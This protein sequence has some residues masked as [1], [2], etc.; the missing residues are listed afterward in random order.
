MSGHGA[1]EDNLQL[2]NFVIHLVRSGKFYCCVISIDARPNLSFASPVTLESLK[3]D[4]LQVMLSYHNRAFSDY[5]HFDI[6]DLFGVQTDH[7][8]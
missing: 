6:G 4:D 2:V 7:A 1:T 3:S 8:N 5:V